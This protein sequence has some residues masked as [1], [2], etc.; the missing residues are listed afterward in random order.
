MA[1]EVRNLA[2]KSSDFAKYTTDIIKNSATAIDT[3]VKVANET[4]VSMNDIAEMSQEITGITDKLL[5]SVESEM[6]ALE[7]IAYAVEAISNIAS[8]NLQVSKDSTNSVDELTQQAL[9]LQ[10]M[11]EEFH[12]KM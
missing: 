5:V 10:K 12:T 8:K 6:V 7:N 11:V 3:G 9:A 2:A 1:N 4:S